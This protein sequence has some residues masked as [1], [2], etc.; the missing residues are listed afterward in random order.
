MP[1]NISLVTVD[2]FS[3]LRRVSDLRRITDCL[4]IVSQS[5]NLSMT[6]YPQDTLNK[7]LLFHKH[8]TNVCCHQGLKNQANYKIMSSLIDSRS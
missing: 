4:A 8:L 7:S 1:S 3:D 5:V 2:N 6:G